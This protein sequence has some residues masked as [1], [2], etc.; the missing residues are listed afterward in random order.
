MPY[1]P[2]GVILPLQKKST[3]GSH[4]IIRSPHLGHMTS[5]EG[6]LTRGRRLQPDAKGVIL[7]L[8]KNPHLGH[9]TSYEGKMKNLTRGIRL[10]LDA[11]VL[12]PL[13]KKTTLGSHDIIR[14]ED[15]N[16]HQGHKAST[17]CHIIPREYIATAEKVHTW[18]T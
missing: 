15:E 16:P 7:P 6:N 9:M 13:Q 18:V 5:H 4:D 2:K 14:R 1:H 3:L 17:G 12:L 11:R 10:Q 8:Q